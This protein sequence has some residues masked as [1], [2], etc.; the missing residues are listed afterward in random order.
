MAIYETKPAASLPDE[1]PPGSRSGSPMR[2][3]NPG[4]IQMALTFFGSSLTS[5][6]DTGRSWSK[7][8]RKSSASCFA[9]PRPVP[10]SERP[11]LS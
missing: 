8:L 9:A 5:S 11:S 1:P 10:P 7:K 6:G 3:L 2:L 4:F